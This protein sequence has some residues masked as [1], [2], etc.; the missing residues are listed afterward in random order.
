MCLEAKSECGGP[1]WRSRDLIRKTKNLQN[2]FVESWWLQVLF[3][4]PTL[5]LFLDSVL[6]LKKVYSWFTSMS[7]VVVSNIIYTVSEWISHLCLY[8]EIVKLFLETSRI[9][10]FLFVIDKKKKK[11][12]KAAFGLPWSARYKVALGVADAIAYLHN[13]TEQC[14]VH[15]DI[16][17]SNIL[18][19]SKK[20]PKVKTKSFSQ[21]EWCIR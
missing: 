1:L 5:C 12:V 4:A 13:G 19:S 11:G 3:I 17:P 7:L 10:Y 21:N 14:V 2:L 8:T 6:T 18:L 9:F 16:K 15:R 20:I